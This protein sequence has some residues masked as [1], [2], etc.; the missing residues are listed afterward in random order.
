LPV[1]KVGDDADAE[2][3]RAALNAYIMPEEVNRY[4]I[5]DKAMRTPSVVVL[6]QDEGTADRAFLYSNPYPGQR[7][8]GFGAPTVKQMRERLKHM[9]SVRF[10]HFAGVGSFDAV[11]RPEIIWL[12]RE[13][14]EV[15]PTAVITADTVPVKSLA[16]EPVRRSL[17]TFLD[18]VDYFMPSDVEAAMLTDNDDPA[19]YERSANELR[20]RFACK[21]IIVKIH[22]RG[23]YLLGAGH[24]SVVHPY[25]L[26]APTDS[27]GAGDAWCAGFISGLVDGSTALDACELGNAAAHYSIQAIGATTNIPTFK[28]VAE[29][30][31]EHQRNR[32][33]IFISH[34]DAE[35][36]KLCA[37]MIVHAGA[38]PIFD[39]AQLRG[40]V[41]E[42][43]VIQMIESSRAVVVLVS[44]DALDSNWVKFEIE[45]A[46]R[47]GL[48]IYPIK[49]TEALEESKI[50]DSV[51]WSTLHRDHHWLPPET[52]APRGMR[53]LLATIRN[54]L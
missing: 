8:G 28:S 43:K 45:H 4:V 33:Q 15:A 25:H 7:T 30:V 50:T 35:L 41:L 9:R 3:I 40:G 6:V 42:K 13:I 18:N 16:D 29:V 54:D 38:T 37:K 36:A 32:L 17:K 24:A 1:V 12:L 23:A 27:T 52:L 10:H 2:Y 47:R 11:T 51:L 34:A 19:D 53:E 5:V 31:R 14:R 26:A 21:N 22:E 49:I 44:N 39:G 46:Q 20:E 48:A